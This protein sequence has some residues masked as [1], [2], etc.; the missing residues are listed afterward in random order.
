MTRWP[1][2]HTGWAILVWKGWDGGSRVQHYNPP[3]TPACPGTSTGLHWR[4]AVTAA[5][6]L[7]LGPLLDS[8]EGKETR[9]G[10]AHSNTHRKACLCLSQIW[11]R[12]YIVKHAKKQLDEIKATADLLEVGTLASRRVLHTLW[13]IF[14]FKVEEVAETNPVPLKVLRAHRAMD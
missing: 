7:M 5:Y 8:G 9:Q 1:V 3:P 14:T 6:P 12:M 11:Q 10:E 4:E 2:P 13:Q